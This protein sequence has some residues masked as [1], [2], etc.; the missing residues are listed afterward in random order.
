VVAEGG[1]TGQAAAFGWGRGWLPG[2]GQVG[3]GRFVWVW[4]WVWAWGG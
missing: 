3:R 2:V 4:V 1:A